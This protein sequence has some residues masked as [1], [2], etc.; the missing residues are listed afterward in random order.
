MVSSEEELSR[1]VYNALRENTVDEIGFGF[2]SEYF[3]LNLLSLRLLERFKDDE[4]LDFWLTHYKVSNKVNVWT[5]DAYHITYVEG[6]SPTDNMKSGD[7]MLAIK[8]KATGKT[9][10]E[11]YIDVKSSKKYPQGSINIDRRVRDWY[12]E[13]DE[14]NLGL[15]SKQTIGRYMANTKVQW[16][17]SIGCS[18][19][20]QFYDK[21][22]M[23]TNFYPHLSKI[24]NHT[25]YVTLRE[26]GVNPISLEEFLEKI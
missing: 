3:L 26:L 23:S 25:Y 22:K 14:D 6:Q 13:F 20:W 17:A 16:Y 9:V 7:I 4:Q 5:E 10:W 11:L 12:D 2:M 18:G 1:Q 8:D 19:Y 15:C 24:N 21:N